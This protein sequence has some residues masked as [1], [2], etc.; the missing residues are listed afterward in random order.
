MRGFTLNSRGQRVLN[1]RSIKD[2]ILNELTDPQEQPR[3][4]ETYNPHKIVRDLKEKQ[5]YTQ[6]EYKN[7][8][9]VLDKR[10]LN[11]ETLT[12]YPYGYC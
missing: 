11:F 8:R 9:L 5:I 7:Y 1:F 12:S 3:L 6:E 2:Y 10:I 4:I